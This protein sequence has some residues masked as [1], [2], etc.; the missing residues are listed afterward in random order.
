MKEQIMVTAIIH[1]GKLDNCLFNLTRIITKKR[2][3][4]I[5]KENQNNAGML[6]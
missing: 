2:R 1:E 3:V 5:Y 4:T 6:I